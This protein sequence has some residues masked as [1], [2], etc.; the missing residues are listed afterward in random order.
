MIDRKFIFTAVNPCNSKYYTQENAL[1]LCAKD[2]AILPALEA[3]HDEC[4]RLGAGIEHL[5]SVALLIGRVRKYQSTHLD[6]V[7]IP[8][9]H[10]D[11]EIDRCIGGKV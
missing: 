11:C 5:N 9:T 4:K 7:K 3:Y 8:D 10:L 6:E 2:Q 1:I